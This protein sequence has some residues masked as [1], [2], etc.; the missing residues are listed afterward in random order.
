LATIKKLSKLFRALSEQSVASAATIADEIVADEENKGHRTAAKILKGSLRPNGRTMHALPPY[1]ISNAVS[2][3]LPAALVRLRETNRLQDVQ[4]RSTVKRDLEDILSE[5]KYSDLLD[6]KKIGRRTK[7]AFYG[8]PGCGKSLTALAL[9]NELKLPVYLV[10]FDAV[11]GSFLGQTAIHLR[12]LFQFA[13]STPCI[14]LF[15][16]I[17]ALARRRGNP[18]DVGEL[19]RIVIAFMQE[20]EHSTPRG[21]IIATSNLPEHLDDAIWRRFDATM[22]FAKPT[23][24][25]LRKFG[26]QVAR[27]FGILLNKRA[28]TLIARARSYAEAEGA[29]RADAR[30]RIIQRR[31][32]SNGKVPR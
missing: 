30:R 28:R 20:L 17:D 14:L 8:P 11:I 27:S 18:S 10:R 1:A 2:T 26:T 3:I 19:D 31:V 22:E 5:W 16:E 24:V 7:L 32:N 4:L 25:E 13:G 6:K 9:G 23:K 12:E 15:D 29:I 21:L